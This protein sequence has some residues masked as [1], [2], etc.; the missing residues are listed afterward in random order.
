MAS[1]SFELT[2]TTTLPSL[3]SAVVVDPNTVLGQ[4]PPRLDILSPV[5]AP[6]PAEPEP[7]IV[8]EPAPEPAIVSEPEPAIVSEPEPAIAEPEPAIVSEPEPAI[9]EPEPAIAEPE[10]VIAEPAPGSCLVFLQPGPAANPNISNVIAIRMA[11]MV[12]SFWVV[13]LVL[14]AVLSVAR[15]ASAIAEPPASSGPAQSPAHRGSLRLP[16]GTRSNTTGELVSGRGLRET[17][18]FL[19][20]QLDRQGIAFEQVGPTRTRGVELTRVLTRSPRTA[21]LAIHVLRRDGK[22]LIFFVPRPSP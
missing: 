19:T 17:T 21:W 2:D 4:F 12:P 11:R 1:L 13:R 7:A 18:E 5:A 15:I 3:I 6:E 16:P 9:A 10:P 8:S 14:A 20:R 22:T